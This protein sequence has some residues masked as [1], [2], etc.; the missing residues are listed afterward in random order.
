MNFEGEIATLAYPKAA[1]FSFTLALVAYN[2]LATIKAALAYTH[3]VTQIETTLSDFYM[4]DEIQATYR[5]MMIAIAHQYWQCFSDMPLTDLASLLKELAAHVNLK[6]FLKQP[7]GIK[8]KKPPL[9]PDPKR[10]HVST[11]QLLSHKKITP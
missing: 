3:G 10:P 6:A 11:L 7:R 1:L 8:K 2:I 4:V 5:G 9:V